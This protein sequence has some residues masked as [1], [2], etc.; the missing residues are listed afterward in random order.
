MKKRIIIISLAVIIVFFVVVLISYIVS[1]SNNKRNNNEGNNK[2]VEVENSLV[3]NNNSQDKSKFVNIDINT[4][5]AREIFDFVPK[6]LQNYNNKM[7]NEY[8]IYSA[9]SKLE[10]KNELTSD[11]SFGEEVFPGYSYKL[12]SEA[13]KDLFGKDIE[14]KKND[15][16]SLPIGYSS[17]DNAFCKYPMGLG[18]AEEVQ[19]IKELQENDKT[20]KLSVY[21]LNIEY[22]INNLDTIFISTK[23]TFKLLENQLS[24]DNT[25]RSSMKEYKLSGIDLD[26][27]AIV[28][29]YKNDIPVIEYELEKIDERGTDY[30]VKNIKII[31]D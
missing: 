26:P 7:S 10:E 13:A 4:Q 14:I 17:T 3:E 11:Y 19:V 27:T 20:F 9:I 23:N 18:S 31:I 21:A 15:K 6:Y 24:D 28:N 22:D 1:G 2:D 30:F 16:Y 12:V 8:I 5:L 25:I 29:E